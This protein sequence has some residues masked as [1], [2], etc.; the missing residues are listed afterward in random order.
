MP[1][2]APHR[3][4]AAFPK[5]LSAA[6]RLCAVFGQPIRHSASPAMQ[7]AALASMGF[8]W[9]YVGCEVAPD[10][11]R[12]AIEGARAMHWIEIGRAHV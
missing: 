8:D 7:N 10:R 3:M 9:R 11:L 1:A 6:T 12:E 5:P 2:Y 4:S